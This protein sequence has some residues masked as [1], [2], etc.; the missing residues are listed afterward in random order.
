MDWTDTNTELPPINKIVWGCS[1]TGEHVWRDICWLR[2]DGEFESLD[3]AESKYYTC[4]VQ[5]WF[6]AVWDNIQNPPEPPGP[7]IM[8]LINQGRFVQAI[9][10]KCNFMSH[11]RLF[12][13]LDPIRSR[14]LQFMVA[15][16]EDDLRKFEAMS[17][18][19]TTG[20]RPVIKK[21]P[22]GYDGPIYLTHNSYN[23]AYESYRVKDSSF[24]ETTRFNPEEFRILSI[25]EVRDLPGR[26]FSPK[27]L[28][29]NRK[30]GII[31]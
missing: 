18:E 23:R 26:L 13:D 12:R 25:E 6:P 30:C 5:W 14:C 31:G 22:L 3:T 17:A 2:E 28:T 15:P 11:S 8:E 21:Y 10:D 1:R 24:L 16:P 29:S 7:T 9:G 27:G 4:C 19:V 20:G